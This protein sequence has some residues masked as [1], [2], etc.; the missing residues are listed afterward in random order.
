MTHQ[1][2]KLVFYTVLLIGLASGLERA[3]GGAGAPSHRRSGRVSGGPHESKRRP[4]VGD[5]RLSNWTSFQAPMETIPFNSSQ[6]ASKTA[7]GTCFQ[8]CGRAPL[9]R[10]ANDFG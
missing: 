10:H 1:S 4:E 2:V 5:R 3:L 9:L 8:G 7:G 6:A